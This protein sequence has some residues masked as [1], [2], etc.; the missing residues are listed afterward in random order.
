MKHSRRPIKSSQQKMRQYELRKIDGTL[1]TSVAFASVNLSTET[2]TATNHGFKTGDRFQV[3]TTGQ[4]L[5]TA[6][7]DY[8]AI[9]VDDNN[10]KVASS[11]AN[12]IA[13]TSVNVVAPTFNFT[14]ADNPNFD[15]VD[16]DIDDVND[17]ITETGHG[18]LTGDS[19]R[20]VST[21]VYPTGLAAATTYYIIKVDNDTIKFAASK[22]DALANTPIE[23]S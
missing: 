10:F 20:L 7:T 3:V 15:F 18:L 12:A 21:G 11:Y 5:L 23:L 19:V 6:S 16:A 22:E 4:L 2:F 14:D 1:S 13:G 9:K 17:T 8:W